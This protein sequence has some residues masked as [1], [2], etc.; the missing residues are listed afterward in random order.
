MIGL[1]KTA[2]PFTI[3]VQFAESN[4]TNWIATA[5][6]IKNPSS[7]GQRSENPLSLLYPNNIDVIALH[8]SHNLIC[9]CTSLI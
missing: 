2:L 9:T 4:F 8:E 7:G 5:N 3:S 6:H 1:N